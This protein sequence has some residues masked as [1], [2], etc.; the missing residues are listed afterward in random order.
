MA[1]LDTKGGFTMKENYRAF[2]A[3]LVALHNLI[4]SLD[5]TY[6]DEAIEYLKECKGVEQ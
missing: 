2:R 3:T 4:E 6:Y 1:R 5:D